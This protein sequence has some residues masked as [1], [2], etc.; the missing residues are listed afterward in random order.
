[1]NKTPAMNSVAPETRETHAIRT[2]EEYKEAIND[3]RRVWIDG[4]RVENVVTHPVTAGMV[5][6][7][8]RWYDLHN[9]PAWDDLLWRSEANGERVPVCFTLPR[10]V[11]ELDVLAQALRGGAFLN[12]GNI[13]HPACWGMLLVGGLWEMMVTLQMG[14]PERCKAYLEDLCAGSRF[15]TGAYS[16]PQVARFKGED[17]RL[18]VHV[19]R[20]RDDGIVVRGGFAI[21]TGA[22]YA[23]EVTSCPLPLPGT[24]EDEALFFA[25]KVGA[26]GVRLFLRKPATY[27]L[28]RY[29]YPLSTR[30]DEQDVSIYLDDVFIPWESVFIYRDPE[31]IGNLERH[32]SLQLLAQLVRK[33]AR[34]EFSL[35][36]ALAAAESLGTSKVPAVEAALTD[37]FLHAETLRTA[38]TAAVYDCEISPAGVAIPGILHMAVGYMYAFENR[39]KTADTLR[40]LGGQSVITA[41]GLGGLR[42]D[43]DSGYLSELFGGGDLIAEQ[44][45]LL[46]NAIRDHTVS[47]LEGREQIY[48]SLATAG[49]FTWRK[50]IMSRAGATEKMVAG[51]LA[52]IEESGGTELPIQARLGK[53]AAGASPF[54]KTK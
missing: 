8:A 16:P 24:R 14:Q 50:R 5:E 30:F 27:S 41:P 23:D 32:F 34:A 46:W 29:A 37:L 52:V 49:S 33:V 51:A 22:V 6:T 20:E 15:L 39:A 1:M 54:V 31:I 18:V 36:L 38:V 10:T 2:G 28:D 9:D 42:S 44:R 48:T 35:G 11:A 19:V 13:S 4:D 45:T 43:E 26:P 53:V 25:F 21:A 40:S 3:G 12:A 47:T 17:E 7:H